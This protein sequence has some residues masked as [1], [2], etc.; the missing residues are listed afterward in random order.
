MDPEGLRSLRST[1]P[2]A[3][4]PGPGGQR[5]PRGRDFGRRSL[6]VSR[7]RDCSSVRES[8]SRNSICRSRKS[9]CVLVCEAGCPGLRFPSRRW[10]SP[11]RHRPGEDR[12]DESRTEPRRNRLPRVEGKPEALGPSER[13]TGILR[14]RRATRRQVIF[15]SSA[16]RAFVPVDPI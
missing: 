1:R 16:R 12:T 9:I 3:R 10:G 14:D 15:G 5:A 4:F 8:V 13:R 2:G 6:G 7:V 11:R